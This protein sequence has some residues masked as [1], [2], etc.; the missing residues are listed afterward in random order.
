MSYN[1]SYMVKCCLQPLLNYYTKA[2]SDAIF[3]MNNE[4]AFD[5]FEDLPGI[6]L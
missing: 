4:P 2:I 1:M 6:C 5:I 3:L